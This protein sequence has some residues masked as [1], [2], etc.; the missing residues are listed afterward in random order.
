[1]PYN[2]VAHKLVVDV[3]V[4]LVNQVLIPEAERSQYLLITS[5]MFFSNTPLILKSPSNK[6][7]NIDWHEIE[8]IFFDLVKNFPFSLHYSHH[9]TKILNVF[10]IQI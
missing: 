6:E 2:C 4:T 5:P 8:Q 3:G 7:S 1:M 9:I 10:W